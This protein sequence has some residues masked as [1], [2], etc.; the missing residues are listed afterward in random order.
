M[1]TRRS[2]LALGASMTAVSL[3]G[4]TGSIP[5]LGDDAM[6]FDAQVGT[7]AES[8]L[9]ETGYDE[10]EV[11]AV[12][13]EES[14]EAGGQTQD[15]IVTNWQAEYDKEIDLGAA[16][17]PI[18]ASQ[19][20]A[21]FSALATPQVS[22]LG[23]TF[24]PIADMSSAELA[25]MVQDRFDDVGDLEQVGEQSVNLAGESTTAGEF[26]GEATLVAEGASVD[27]SLYI[28][29]AVESGDDLIVG[30]GGCP[31]DLRE[32]EQPNIFAM[33]EAVNHEG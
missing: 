4:C 8:T 11:A 3:A 19:R 14:F 18:D 20:A 1:H 31:T 24:N 15:V 10:Q 21:V 29:E 16:G 2:A 12:E 9:D 32:E 30:V 7:V 23:R 6:R 25:E 17:V 22:V 13:I 26:E 33:M 5:F 27:L 28:A